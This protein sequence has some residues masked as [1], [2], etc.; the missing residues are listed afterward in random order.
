MLLW[1]QHCKLDDV[2]SVMIGYDINGR[3]VERWDNNI[4]GVLSSFLNF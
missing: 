3:D 2:A 1:L 4:L